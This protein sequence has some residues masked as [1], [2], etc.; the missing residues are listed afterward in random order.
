M[1]MPSCESAAGQATVRR[2]AATV[3]SGAK[4]GA[5]RVQRRAFASARGTAAAAPRESRA[6]HMRHAAGPDALAMG[7]SRLCPARARG[8]EKKERSHQL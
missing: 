7:G 6:R 4:V 1:L 2:W 5:R 8:T 3:G